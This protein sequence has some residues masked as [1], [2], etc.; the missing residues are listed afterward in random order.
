LRGHDVRRAPRFAEEQFVLQPEQF[1]DVWGGATTSPERELAAAMLQAAAVD[2]QKYRHPRDRR[3]QRTYW[4][5]YEW[6]ASVD[7]TW[8]F[9][10]VNLCET[11]R[12]SPEALR[13]RL[14]RAPTGEVAEAA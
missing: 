9:S 6:V 1:R 13:E 4:H 10:F 11:L 5:A 7:R 12:L 14:L 3:G 2:L 8:P